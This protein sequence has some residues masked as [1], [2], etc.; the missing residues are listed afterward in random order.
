LVDGAAPEIR[1]RTYSL[2]YA[3]Y[4]LSVPY[5]PRSLVLCCFA[6]DYQQSGNAWLSVIDDST[7][8]HGRFFSEQ[9]S[10][11]HFLRVMSGED[12]G[13]LSVLRD[14]LKISYSLYWSISKRGRLESDSV[15]NQGQI[16]DFF[17]TVKITE[18]M[19]KCLSP[20]FME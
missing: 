20:F 15:E 13:Q 6:S 8:F 12:I 7:H 4:P 11:C 10:Y 17:H 19:S 2:P 14:F 1:R 9:F 16:S 18:G 3:A 5:G